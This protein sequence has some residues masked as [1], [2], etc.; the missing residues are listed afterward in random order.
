MEGRRYSTRWL[1]YMAQAAQ[2]AAIHLVIL[3]KRDVAAAPQ[4]TPS[5]QPAHSQEDEVK[6][7]EG[8]RR[9]FDS[10]EFLPRKVARG[11]ETL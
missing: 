8:N 9:C 3:V 2:G 7:G 10:F 5:R 1:T 4:L 11:R 6:G